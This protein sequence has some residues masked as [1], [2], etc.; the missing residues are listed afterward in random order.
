M[1][2]LVTGATGLV[3]KELVTHLRQRGHTVVEAS[4]QGGGAGEGERLVWDAVGPLPD[5]GTLDAIVHLAGERVIGKRWTKRQKERLRS[6]RVASCH[7]LVAWLAQRPAD[8]RPALIAA[9]AVGY[10]GVWPKDPC[11]ETHEPGP[12]FLAQLC[13][14]WQAAAQAAPTRVAVLRFGHIMAAGGY[15]GKLLPFAKWHLGGAIGG[16]RQPMPWVDIED[17]V[18]ALT[19]AVEQKQAQGVYNVVSPGAAGMTQKAFA[20]RL[21]QVLGKPRQLPIPALALK[22]R[23]GFKVAGVLVGGQD[24][25]PVRLQESGFAFQHTDLEDTLVRVTRRA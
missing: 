20:R 12:D 2:V 22:F 7:R 5:P 1:R 4:R 3:G 14:E 11:P 23:F 18:R 17:V 6:S 15:L 10:Y 9:N 19:W 21:G 24:A 16:G 25:R 13:L 8:K